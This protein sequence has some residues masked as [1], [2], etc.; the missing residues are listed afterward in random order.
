[1]CRFFAGLDAQD[2]VSVEALLAPAYTLHLAGNPDPMDRAGFRQ[3]AQGFFVAL[4]DVTHV[5]EDQFAAGEKVMTRI[6]VRGTHRGD[7]RGIPPT[8]RPVVL[9]SVNVH[10]VENGRIVEQWI[11]F[12]SASL[13][14]QLG[15]GS[16]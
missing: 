8:D 5:I 9:D 2:L 13:M 15:R 6:V 16:G 1:V 11:S 12:D 3:F 14:Q 10:Y 4:P 7:F